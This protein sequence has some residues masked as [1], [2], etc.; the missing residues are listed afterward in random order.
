MNY[1][2]RKTRPVM[3]GPVDERRAIAV[4]LLWQS[5]IFDTAEIGSLLALQ[6]DQV[7]RTI[8]AARAVA[9]EVTNVQP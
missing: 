7:S 4:L 6:E 2:I 1:H 3:G 9:R 8:H 5:R